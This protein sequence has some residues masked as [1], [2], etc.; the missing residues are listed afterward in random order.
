MSNIPRSSNRRSWTPAKPKTESKYN[1]NIK[2]YTSKAWRTLRNQYIN[3]NPLCEECLRN[4]RYIDAYFID[5]IK[6]INT[7]G[8]LL[9]INNLQALCKRC[10]ARKR[11]YESYEKRLNNI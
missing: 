1:A 3:A 11:G 4:D 7:G 8:E 6:S 5:H 10:D 2:F 9:D